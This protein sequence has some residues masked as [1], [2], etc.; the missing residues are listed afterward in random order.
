VRGEI[1]A[2]RGTADSRAFDATAIFTDARPAVR[3]DYFARVVFVAG[4]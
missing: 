4:P 1:V 3:A 2:A